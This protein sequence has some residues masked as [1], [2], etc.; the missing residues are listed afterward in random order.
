MEAKRLGDMA[1]TE[2]WAMLMQHLV[3]EPAWLNRRL[4]VPRPADLAYDGVDAAKKKLAAI[5]HAAPVGAT[6]ID[7]MRTL[8]TAIPAD[9]RI[10]IDECMD[11][12]GVRV[13][14]KSDSSKWSMRSSSSSSARTPS[15][16]C[17]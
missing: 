12:E 4:D 11:A 16:M 6:A 5:E 2:G 1:V 7:V 9:L 17:R 15:P 13:R 10:D 14:A 3:T 8:A